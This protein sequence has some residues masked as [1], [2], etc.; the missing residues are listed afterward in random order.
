MAMCGLNVCFTNIRSEM[1]SILIQKSLQMGAD[2]HTHMFTEVT[3]LV[4]G[5]TQSRKYIVGTDWN[6]IY[7]LIYRLFWKL[8]IRIQFQA[9]ENNI[10]TVTEKWVED[11]WESSVKNLRPIIPNSSEDFKRI[12]EANKCPVFHGATICASNVSADEK[13]RLARLIDAN[14]GTY[15]AQE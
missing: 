14:G 12:T 4:V 2:V 15:S 3:H 7:R 1:R 13:A 11:L 6:S 9:C 5:E 8:F 10:T